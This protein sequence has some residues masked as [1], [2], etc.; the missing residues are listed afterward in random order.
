MSFEKAKHSFEYDFFAEKERYNFHDITSNGFT[1]N[2]GITVPTIS[3][4]MEPNYVNNLKKQVYDQFF[5]NTLSRK[6]PIIDV[7][8]PC[9]GHYYCSY[10]GVYFDA[11]IGVGQKLIDDQHPNIKNMIKLLSENNML[12]RR[13]S[14]TNDV[15]IAR[16]E[17][18]VKTP[19]DLSNLIT[20]IA[21]NAFP[22]S[23]PYKSYFSNSGAEAIEAAIKLAC[24]KTHHNLIQKYGYNFEKK[25]MEDL[26]IKINENFDHPYDKD[27]LY[28]NYPFFFIAMKGAFHGR[29][30][31]ALSLTHVRPVQKRGY[32]LSI[33]VKHISFNGE[34][35]ELTSIVDTRT[36]KEIYE[37]HESVSQI[38]NNGRI[39]KELVAGLV[40]EV[41]QGEGGYIIAD[42][43]WINSIVQFCRNNNI[44]II[45]DEVQ[46]FART[47]KTFASEHFGIEPDIIAISKASVMGITLAS[48]KYS[49]AL[50]K[51]WHSNTWGGGK[52][53]DNNLAWTVLDTYI[54]YSD[55][56][57]LGNT[58]QLNQQIKAEYI[59]YKF[60]Q[61]AENHPKT[62]MKYSGL[63][64]MWGFTVK[65]RDEVCIEALNNGLKLLSCGVTREESAIRALFL[66][67]VLTKEID[68]FVSLL[69]ITLINIEK[70]KSL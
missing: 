32:P 15:M 4:C 14:I 11:D 68:D 19:Q 51:G 17:S 61:L 70:R 64:G 33:N 26:K 16:P 5:P 46:T 69:D 56:L 44:S 1:L 2:R 36:L 35:S 34:I 47:G 30:L 28:N 24:R 41:Y 38:I 25:L 45:A 43:N 27:P 55:P 49:E 54:N 12:V 62:L 48:A 53:F 18:D 52:V 59:D 39:P 6:A 66:S 20:G 67:D 9:T 65:F 31:G 58:Y 22:K 42:K 3:N 63:G 23:S 57:F 40:I 7:S 21:N 60:Q 29:T 8:L 10:N 37:E 13:E 50:P